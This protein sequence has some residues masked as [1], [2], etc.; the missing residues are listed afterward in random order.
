MIKV[1]ID[2]NIIVSAFL[3]RHSIPEIIFSLAK[4][5]TFHTCLTQDVFNEYTTVLRRPKFRILRY[6]D[7]VKELSVLKKNALWVK[8]ISI[9][10]DLEDKSDLKFLACAASAKADFLITG[11][12][13]DFPQQFSTTAIVTPRA[14]YNEMF[15]KLSFVA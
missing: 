12:A 5:Q 2:T 1:V 11:N 8:P 15:E 10:G 14:F 3:K 6:T 13:K 9:K 4:Q 7:V